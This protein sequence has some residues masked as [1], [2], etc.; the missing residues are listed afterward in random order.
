MVTRMPVGSGTVEDVR[1]EARGEF[2]PRAALGL[3]CALLV[4]DF[5]DRQVVV[6]AFPYLRAEWAL[7][8]VQLGG[9]VSAVSV[10][11][12]LGTFPVAL[13]VDSWNRVRAI[14]VMGTVWSGAMAAC[15]FA[16]GYPALL[17][18]RI[19]IGVGQA[20]FG[21]AA[22]ALLA[23]TFPA[24]PRAAGLSVFPGGAP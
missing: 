7:S 15:A 19:G 12:A 16:H 13:V 17:A 1:E 22:L 8:E 24:A 2:S 10:V 23:A 18:G 20:G 6:S 9:L 11:V 3:L 21:P 5:A 4:V 14:A